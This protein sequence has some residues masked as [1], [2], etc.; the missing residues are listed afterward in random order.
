MNWKLWCLVAV[1]L[2]IMLGLGVWQLQRADQKQIALDKFNRQLEQPAQE[3]NHFLKNPS[4]YAKVSLEGVYLDQDWLL[5]N[6]IEEGKFGYRVYT[7]FCLKKNTE[8]VAEDKCILADR[9]WIAGSLDRNILPTLARPGGMLQIVGR[10]DQLN[11]TIMLG[12]SEPLTATPYRVQQIQLEQISGIT[13]HSLAPWIIRLLPGQ[14]GVNRQTWQ[15][16]VMGPEKH[17]G[18]AVQWFAMAIALIGLALWR[19]FRPE[20]T[21]PSES[22]PSDPVA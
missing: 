16:V 13:K 20:R 15:P 7:P 4:L 9:G 5:D 1:L 14:A 11:S 10:V 19:Q 6:Q 21:M 2:P 12:D 22:G 18:Y 3:W 17:L 8:D